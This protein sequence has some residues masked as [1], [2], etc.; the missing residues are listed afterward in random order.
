MRKV[1]RTVILSAQD[2]IG[3]LN[4]K[5]LTHLDLAVASGEIAKPHIWKDSQLEI[6]WER[7]SV[8]EQNYIGHLQ[9]LG[10]EVVKIDGIDITD[11][12]VKQTMEAM[13]NGEKIIAQGAFSFEG[14][15]GRTDILRRIEIPSSLGNWSY[16]VIDTKL[17]RET[18]GGTILQLCL[19]SDLLAQVQGLL[20]EF[21]YVVVPWSN[22]KPMQFRVHDYAAYYRRVKS[23][24]EQMTTDP[25][26]PNTYP[27]I[28]EH[29]DICR[30]H[31][32][33]DKKRREDDH[34]CLV[35]GITK[36][37][38]GELARQKTD[39]ANRP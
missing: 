24:L 7:G 20:P 36:I 28:K 26:H 3:H 11:E 10:L 33:C 35:A 34:L 38:I 2:L 17:A 32:D 19:Y 31:V 27:D 30:W 5:H 39:T 4:C 13:Q 21:M 12:A 8:H 23:S 37:Q 1:G 16:E 22:F 15:C 18:K 14:W 6:L 25:D 29:C 9:S